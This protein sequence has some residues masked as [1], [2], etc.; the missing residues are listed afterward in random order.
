MSRL[1]NAMELVAIDSVS[2]NERDIA[3][4][5]ET[6]LRENSSLEVK[7]I[8]DNVIARTQN[9][10]SARVIVAGHI[11]TV[12]GDV[13]E[14]RI[15]DSVLHGL[16][17]CD[18]KGSV[19]V[20]L[21]LALETNERSKDIT[22]VFYA[23]EEIARSESG[24][25]EIARERPDLL[26]GD[27]AILGEPSNGIVEA[28]CQGN[29]RVMLTLKGKRAHSA[30]PFVG[31]NAIHRLAPV[32]QRI[33]EFTP[34]AVELDGVVFTEQLQ[35]VMVN[36]GIA[37]N[38]VPDSVTLTINHRVAPDRSVAEAECWLR[39]YLGELI[40]GEDQF[41]LLDAAPSAK[42][43]LDN[44]YLRSLVEITRVQPVAKVGWTDV[45]TFQELGIAATNFGAGDP[46]LA[47]RSDEFVTLGELDDYAGKLRWWLA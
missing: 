2:R 44:E 46:L 30:R 18:M 29:L 7:R 3:D 36:G 11:D 25:L 13:R 8:G 5:L 1:E 20:M 19:S 31:R 39:E 32:L 22:W 9:G 17:A 27:A 37:G 6:R 28:G 15:A 21:E 4:F 34:R 41:E 23:K 40:E 14:A 43:S 12:P 42:P 35:A 10:C 16:G 24:L 38:V 33:S 26:V 47:H 45:A